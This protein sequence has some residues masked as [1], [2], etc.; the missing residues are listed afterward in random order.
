MIQD[1]MNKTAADR[2]WVRSIEEAVREQARARNGGSGPLT[3]REAGQI[4][5]CLRTADDLD[6][7]SSELFGEYIDSSQ[8]NGT[9]RSEP[10]IGHVMDAANAQLADL[11]AVGP[12][13]SASTSLGHATR[14]D[15][16]PR[17]REVRGRDVWRVGVRSDQITVT[18][19]RDLAM[20]AIDSYRDD[21]LPDSTR[22]LV[23]RALSR[24]DAGVDVAS[25]VRA[26]TDPGA[27]AAFR[28]VW[29]GYPVA[30]LERDEAQ[31]FTDLQ[32]RAAAIGANT[33]GG[34]AVPLAVDP[35]W[36]AEADITTNPFMTIARRETI[37]TG[38]YTGV[39]ANQ[40]TAS[41]D[42]EAEEVSDDMAVLDRVQITANR[43]Q[44]FV[45]FSFE[46]AA[47]VPDFQ[48]QVRQLQAEGID[49]AL[50]LGF[51]VG[52]GASNEPTGVVTDLVAQA[53]QCV[54][55][56]GSA[57][58]FV[59]AD[60]PALMSVVKDR[61]YAAGSFLMHRSTAFAIRELIQSEN[62]AAGV[63]T[64]PS[65][66][67][68]PARLYGRPVYLSSA[69]DSDLTTTGQNVIVFGDFNRFA[70][71]SAA[72]SIVD[73]VPHVFG[74]NQRPTGQA[75]IYSFSRWGSGLTDTANGTPAPALTVL[76]IQ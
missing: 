29:D 49:D 74:S 3:Q 8:A 18:A 63:W 33:T 7:K 38:T 21:D 76:Q 25:Y 43:L 67:D 1:E 9:L 45:P 73:V 24:K 11:A 5:H 46:V 58:S 64:D 47:D 68:V 19:A 34:F 54:T 53:G 26:A 17:R 51:A 27:E 72:P 14:R 20:E 23:E 42:A 31:A 48:N 35:A 37:M 13:G 57:G 22:A 75:G 65:S 61:S 44:S 16:G 56:T 59:L 40:V 36:I 69:M 70:V 28:K 39:Q 66:D 4:K 6:R 50:G 12:A 15:D 71:V 30:A 55:A 10:A 60:V 2:H 32:K 52:T 62:S 41:W